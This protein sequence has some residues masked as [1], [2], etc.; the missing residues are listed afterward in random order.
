MFS[1]DFFKKNLLFLV[2]KKFINLLGGIT[3]DPEGKIIGA[4]SM[5]MNL[6]GKMNVTEAHLE[7][8]GQ[9]QPLGD[10]IALEQID[11]KTKSIENKFI[12]ILEHEKEENNFIH[13]GKCKMKDKEAYLVKWVRK[14]ESKIS[15]SQNVSDRLLAQ[16]RMISLNSFFSIRFHHCQ[17][18]F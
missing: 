7:K 9:N 16:L 3:Y 4:K 17:E 6:Y 8:I 12:D 2:K 1:K 5:K 18:F 13:I 14:G 15:K 10:Q 11:D